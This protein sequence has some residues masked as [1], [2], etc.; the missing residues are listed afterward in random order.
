VSALLDTHSLFTEQMISAYQTEQDNAE[1]HEAVF[2][3][4]HE[5]HPK[6]Y[7]KQTESD[8]SFHSSAPMVCLILIYEKIK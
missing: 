5:N 7:P 6:G 1:G 3:E 8:E 2:D 4:K